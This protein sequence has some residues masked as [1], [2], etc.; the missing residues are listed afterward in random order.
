MA[1]THDERGLDRRELLGLAAGVAAGA[2]AVSAQAAEPPSEIVAMS[3]RQLSAAIKARKVSCVE[4]MGA[5]LDHIAA[6]N[7][8]VNA[9][10]GMPPR[11]GLLRQA[12]ERDA[13][14]A[15]G[16]K[17]A[18]LHGLPHAV[19]DLQ[20][21][22]GLPF[23]QG[24]PIYRDTVAT[25]DSIMVERLRK[26][27][28]VFIGKTNTPEFGLGSHTYN[29]VWGVTRNPYDLT[30]SAGGSSGGAAAAL[31]A[32]MLPLADGSDFGGSLRNPAGW[33]NVV[34]FRTTQGRVPVHG[35]EDWIPGM[36]VTGPMARSVADVAFL[37]SVQAGYDARAPLSL[38]GD[39]REFLGALEGP[40]NG[41]RIGWLGDFGGAAAY[42]PEVLA[43][44]RA[45]LKSFEALG[46]TVEDATVAYPAEKAWQAFVRLRGW[47]QGGALADLYNDPAKRPLLKPEAIYEIELG[48]GLSAYD[49][50]AASMVRTEWAQAV[51]QLFA[52]YDV[53]V[54][55]TAQLF[56][57]DADDQHWPKTVAGRDMRTY[58]EDDGR[59]P[60]DPDRLS[61]ARGPGG[62]R[63]PKFKRGG[64][65]DRPADCRPGA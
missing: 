34:G 7:P 63:A 11:E 25:T 62:V 10:V 52:R 17:V 23:T 65:A 51:R 24:S 14:L 47:M 21:V 9:I 39:G 58:H 1:D 46:C 53:L 4:V 29:P 30:K 3:A 22:K 61:I 55:P 48:R 20:P 15:R 33:N 18:P 19:K 40:V 35:R 12:G 16:D 42:E 41:K 36:G 32:R 6:V 60:G 38:E 49:V 50:Q 31:A 56:A 59:V 45:A 8:Q 54:S 5:F 26:A 27:G 57:F 13:A 37:L 28:V 44:C 2:A 64:H 43:A